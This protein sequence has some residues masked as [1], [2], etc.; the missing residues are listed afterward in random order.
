MENVI[1]KETILDKCFEQDFPNER[2]DVYM[3]NIYKK[4]YEAGLNNLQKYF[5]EQKMIAEINRE[6]HA[7]H[8]DVHIR[9]INELLSV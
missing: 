8:Y 6:K 5:K 9:K 2:P 1:K 7:N 4:G 3:E